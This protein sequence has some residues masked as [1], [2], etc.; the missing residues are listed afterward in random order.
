MKPR[1][2]HFLKSEANILDTFTIVSDQYGHTAGISI[3]LQDFVEAY[4]KGK[5][6]KPRYHLHKEYPCTL[7]GVAGNFESDTHDFGTIRMIQGALDEDE[8]FYIR[9]ETEKDYYLI[10][11]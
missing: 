7:H 9:F 5:P 6:L 3:I 8:N 11:Y 4:K 2:H 1:I 10:K